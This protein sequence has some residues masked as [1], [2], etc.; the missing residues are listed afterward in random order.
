MPSHKQ[1]LHSPNSH[2]LQSSQVTRAFTFCREFIDESSRLHQSTTRST[3]NTTS[4]FAAV[5]CKETSNAF[6]TIAAVPKL[7]ASTSIVKTGVA[8]SR[9]KSASRQDGSRSEPSVSKSE[10]SNP[11]SLSRRIG[12]ELVKTRTDVW[13]ENRWEPCRSAPL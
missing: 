13:R 1:R 9:G 5:R 2:G 10:T 12:P 7:K 3:H 8:L 4:L 11:P 6:D